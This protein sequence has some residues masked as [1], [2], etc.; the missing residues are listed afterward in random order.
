MWSNEKNNIQ[1]KIPTTKNIILEHCNNSN[2]FQY[3]NFESTCNTE[4][5]NHILSNNIQQR[6]ATSYTKLKS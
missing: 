6:K 2:S 3:R 1:I 5:N 4:I